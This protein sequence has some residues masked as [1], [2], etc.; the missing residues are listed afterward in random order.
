MAGETFPGGELGDR[1]RG[2]ASICV[3]AALFA[4]VDSSSKFA[5][6]AGVP[7]LEVVWARYAISLVVAALVLRPWRRPADY[8]TRRPMWQA[9]RAVFLLMSTVFSF[10]AIQHLQLSESTA[11]SF[12][13]PLVVTAL[14]G[15]VLG[16]WAGIHRW[17]AIV[18]GFIGVL[19]VVHPTPGDFNPAVLA[20]IGNALAYSAYVLATRFLSTTETPGAMLI[21]GSLVATVA[22]TPALPASHLVMPG[23]SATLALVICGAAGAISHLFIILGYRH[24]PTPVLAPFSYTQILWAAALGYLVF[25]DLPTLT[26][27]IGAAVIIASGLYIL[28]RH[29]VWRARP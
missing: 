26:T 29:R 27:L 14:A 24:A 12:V 21:Y 5:T 6:H 15:P 25:G 4:C 2:I 1:L 11:I 8:I 19:I 18:V 28:Y 17:A 3:A 16:E 23:W 10:I 7:T 20:A 13:S 22:L 9:L